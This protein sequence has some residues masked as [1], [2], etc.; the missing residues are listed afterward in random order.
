MNMFLMWILIGTAVGFFANLIE[1]SWGTKTLWLSI[2]LGIIGASI[3]GVIGEVATH[4]GNVQSFIS[5]LFYI[6]MG[7]FLS[8]IVPSKDNIV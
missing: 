6:V 3:G 4:S 8:V 7:S 1:I 2:A 5:P